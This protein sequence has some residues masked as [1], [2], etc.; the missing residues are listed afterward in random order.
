VKEYQA[1]H[2]ISSLEII[3]LTPSGLPGIYPDDA[4]GLTDEP[5][6]RAANDEKPAKKEGGKVS[7]K[8]NG[9]KVGQKE[10]SK[11]KVREKE[12]A[13]GEEREKEEAPAAADDMRVLVIGVLREYKNNRIKVSAGNFP[14][15]AELPETAPVSVDVRHCEWVRPG[16]KIELTARYFPA[17]RGRAEGERMTITASQPLLPDEKANKGRRR[18]GHEKK[19]EDTPKKS[20]DKVK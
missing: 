6:K 15:A 1:T 13:R 11:E 8:E 10:K 7:E 5:F 16:D 9:E 18:G 14:V 20:D 19:P 2:P 17:M 3:T 4:G 12:D